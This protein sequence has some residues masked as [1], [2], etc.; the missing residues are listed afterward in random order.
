MKYTSDDSNK[1]IGLSDFKVLNQ[2]VD[3]IFPPET[4]EARTK[5]VVCYDN[6]LN[7]ER[8]ELT[9]KQKESMGIIDFSRIF[10]K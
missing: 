4:K 6:S 10:I 2:K 7:V 1:F 3:G 9:N 5:V 8:D